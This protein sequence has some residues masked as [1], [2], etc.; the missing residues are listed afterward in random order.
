MTLRS[1][2]LGIV[3]VL[4]ACLLYAFSTFE[5]VDANKDLLKSYPSFESQNFYGKTFNEKGLLTQE[6]NAQNVKY[7]KDRDLI[8]VHKGSL[9]FFEHQEKDSKAYNVKADNVLFYLEKESYLNG[10]VILTPLNKDAP[11]SKIL[12]DK[13]KIDLEKN[14]ISSDAQITIIGPKYI[15]IAEGFIGDLNKKTIDLKG[16][17]HATYQP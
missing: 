14:I 12:T 10:N 5:K 2:F 3:L 1:L 17:P 6:I 4:V 13:V 9:N 16:N 7:Y 8:K 15:N 11:F